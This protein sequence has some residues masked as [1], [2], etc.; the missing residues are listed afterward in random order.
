MSM[1]DGAALSP[2]SGDAERAVGGV[3]GLLASLLTRKVCPMRTGHA[4]ADF[5]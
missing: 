5:T 3:D 2:A 4:D 1:L